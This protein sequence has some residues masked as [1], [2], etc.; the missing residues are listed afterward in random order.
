[1]QA[2]GEA[3][4]LPKIL[5]VLEFRDGLIDSGDGAV[6]A[7][8]MRLEMSELYDGLDLDAPHMPKAGPAEM[9][10]PA[11]AFL[12]GYLDGAPVCCG[13]LKRLDQDACEIKRMYVAPAARGRGV[14]KALLAALE[15]RARLMGFR[16]A[17]LDTGPRQPHAQQLYE[18]QGY[19]SIECFNGNTVAMFFGE[20]PL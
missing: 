1:L 14:A 11:G 17:R 4:V 12:V 3:S 15:D 8:A 20:K 6:L 19:R 10:P 13:G 16:L 2:V 5:A 7:D 9:N 18:S